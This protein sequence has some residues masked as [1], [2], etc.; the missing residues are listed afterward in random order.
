LSSSGRVVNKVAEEGDQLA[1]AAVLGQRKLVA[2]IGEVGSRAGLR[3]GDCWNS[4]T[5]RE[6]D[7]CSRGGTLLN[8]IGNKVID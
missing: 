8:A 1:G 4:H 3:V 5:K 2:G 6:R 7:W